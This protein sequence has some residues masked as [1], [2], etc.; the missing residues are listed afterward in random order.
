MRGVEACLFRFV[1]FWLFAFV[2]WI[3][4]SIF[5]LWDGSERGVSIDQM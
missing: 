4:G 3:E 2:C 1:M 5:E